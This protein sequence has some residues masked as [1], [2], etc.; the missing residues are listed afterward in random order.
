MRIGIITKTF[1]RPTLEAT[2]DAIQNHRL[3]RV[4]FNP[5]SAG[6]EIMPPAL[7]PD[8][9]QGIRRACEARS[10]QIAAAQ[11]AYNILDPNLE[12]RRENFRSLRALTSACSA[13]GTN[14]ITLCTGTRDPQD[15][16]KRHPDNDSPQAWAEMVAELRPIV[17]LGEEF[18]VVMG[19]EPEVSNVM[20][21]ARKARRLL[22]E[23]GSDHLKIIMDGA[24][25]FGHGD[26]KRMREVLDEAFDLL[27]PDIALAH[28]K[29]L[30]RDG[31]AGQEAAGQGKLDYPYYLRLLRRSGYQGALILH[32][33]S[34]DQVAGCIDFLER[35]LTESAQSSQS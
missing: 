28:A 33:L 17:R 35:S 14:M 34:E 11:G 30:A 9:A 23:I 19:V 26:L 18:G 22:E 25:L 10:I 12:R 6:L 31:E 29:D 21:S 5:Q 13:L 2:L 1:V 16:W 27:G 32:S 20:S 4:Q 15:M 3:T 24:N 8:R 7:D